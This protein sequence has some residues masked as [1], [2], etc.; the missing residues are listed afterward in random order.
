MLQTY[1]D[2]ININ[3]DVIFRLSSIDSLPNSWRPN[4][5]VA[6]KVSNLDELKKFI[7]LKNAGLSNLLL[8][9]SE[10]YIFSLADNIAKILDTENTLEEDDVISFI[11]KFNELRILYRRSDMHHTVFLTNHCNSNCL[12]CSQPPTKS[13]DLWLI[14]E[15]ILIAEHINQSPNTI[16]FTGGEPLLLG[17]KLPFILNHYFNL[18]PNSALQV[19]TNGRLFSQDKLTE[20]IF[21]ELNSSVNWQIP[22]YGHADFIHD[23]VVQTYKAF[24]QTIYGILALQEHHQSIQIRTVLIK[25]VLDNLP[26]IA[27]FITRNLPFV[28]EV[29]L[30][31]CEPTGFALANKELCR[32]DLREW[33]DKIINAVEI[34]VRGNLGVVIMNA[35]LCVLPSELWVHAHQSISD[36]KRVYTNICDD[37]K[38]KSQCS[39]LFASYKASW[40]PSIIN[41]I[42]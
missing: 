15:A 29:A 10:N 24:D 1:C 38:V 22:L 33:H 16:G 19:L 11:H 34:L 32:V 4:I 35:P 3:N 21:S 31:V 39:G 20:R 42:N 41:P 27:E 37:C 6:V 9:T 30:M 2:S 40:L 7:N 23:Y 14:D 8:L 25:P 12:M 26:K 18:H 28:C 13:P 17:D 5:N 36:W